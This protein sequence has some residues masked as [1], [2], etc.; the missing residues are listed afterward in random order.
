MINLPYLVVI[1]CR[2]VNLQVCVLHEGE[3]S[4]D[5]LEIGHCS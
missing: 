2:A 4:D 5:L 3:R 1:L